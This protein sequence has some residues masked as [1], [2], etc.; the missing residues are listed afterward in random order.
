MGRN[1]LRQI[2][3]QEQTIKERRKTREKECKM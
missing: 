3:K 1:T 2:L